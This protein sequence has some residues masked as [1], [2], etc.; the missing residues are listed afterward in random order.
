[1]A[2]AF[3]PEHAPL[4]Q[5]QVE[6][7]VEEAAMHAPK[8]DLLIFAAFQFDPEAAKDIDETNLPGTTLLRVEMNTDL[9]T[10]DLKKG[11]TSNESFWLIGQPEIKIEA[12][13]NDRYKVS[14]LGFDYFSLKS[15]KRVSGGR[16]QIAVWLL[17]T[18]YDGRSLFP[19]QVFFPLSK[20]KHGWEKLGKALR[21]SIDQELIKAYE[22]TI[23]LPFKAGEHRRVAV[24]I[25]DDRGI[26][27][28]A[29]RDLGNQQ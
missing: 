13:G 17:D 21:S 29:V 22:G 14:V 16:D 2:V 11:R 4:E 24:K 19:R 7:A 9:Q 1:M 27:S 28:L 23:S 20:R 26:E 10:D 12:L 3:G 15:G 25:V 18:D 6:R 5:R 8:P